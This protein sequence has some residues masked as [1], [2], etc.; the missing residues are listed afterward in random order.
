MA[1]PTSA[2]WTATWTG[3]RPRAVPGRADGVVEVAGARAVDGDAGLVAAVDP[4]RL[5]ARDGAGG[6][7]PGGAPRPPPA[8]RPTRR[9]WVA[10]ASARSR[11][12]AAGPPGTRL[13]AARPSAMTAAVA[14]TAC[15]EPATNGPATRAWP[16][17]G[18]SSSWPSRTTTSRPTE[19]GSLAAGPARERDGA[20]RELRVRFDDEAAGAVLDGAD[21]HPAGPLDQRH[22]GRRRA[23][24]VDL[25]LGVDEVV[26]DQLARERRWHEDAVVLGRRAVGPGPRNS[27]GVV[28]SASTG[29]RKPKPRGWGRKRARNGHGRT[30]GGAG[31]WRWTPGPGA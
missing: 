26:G 13:G 1:R 31:R 8:S 6:V 5:R 27:V 28:P 14:R 16:S 15:G 17:G 20:R 9:V 10:V 30:H 21:E 11:P 7:E 25:H 24:L 22:R 2:M 12:A 29:V 18:P 4:R 3:G 19:V 23:L